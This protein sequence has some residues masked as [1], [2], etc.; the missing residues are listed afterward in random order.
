MSKNRLKLIAL[1]LALAW[2]PTFAATQPQIDTARNKG[3]WWLIAHQNGDGSWGKGVAVIASSATGVEAFNTAGVRG[4]IYSRAYSFLVNAPALSVDTL[5]RQVAA[6]SAAGGNVDRLSA[7]LLKTR[8]QYMAWG[9]YSNYETSFPDTALALSA[10]LPNAS[11]STTDVVKAGCQIWSARRTDGGWSYSAAGYTGTTTSSILPTVY[12][13][14]ALDAAQKSRSLPN[15]YACGEWTDYAAIVAAGINWLLTQ[16]NGDGGFGPAGVSTV[17]DTALVYQAL[18]LLRPSDPAIGPALD[19]LI[20]KQNPADGGWGNDAFQTALVMK[21][22]PAPLTPLLDTDKD[23]V[24]DAVEAYMGTN[25]LVADSRGAASGNGQSV[26]GITVPTEIAAELIIGQAFG[27]YALTVSGGTG[28]YTWA[29][30]SGILPPGINLATG[31]GIISG[32]PTDLGSYSFTYSV[33]DSLLATAQTTGQINV[34][35]APPS[36]ATG[37]INGD[38]KVDAADVALAE[39]FALGLAVP[40]TA[41]LQAADVSPVGRPDG[42]IDAADVARIRLKALGLE[43]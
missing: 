6:V 3:L 2:S 23:G 10:L 8:N 5:A 14:I 40:T 35:A 1:S 20:S 19:Y 30:V 18:R 26:E 36:A 13:A 9:A 12:N 38:D 25:P 39:R 43:K 27:P 7:D 33:T 37:N 11:Y 42:K 34:Y 28:P 16:R 22:L 4:P 41:Q 15:N 31:T 24:P 32:T 21:A 17:L 29:L